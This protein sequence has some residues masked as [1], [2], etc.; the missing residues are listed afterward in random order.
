[1]TVESSRKVPKSF[2]GRRPMITRGGATQYRGG[3]RGG[4]QASNR[5]YQRQTQYTSLRGNRGGYNQRGRGSFRGRGGYRNQY[6][7]ENAKEPSLPILPSW[8]LVEEVEFD[9]L[10]V[11]ITPPTSET[12]LGLGTLERYVDSYD[13]ATPRLAK[14]VAAA[15]LGEV[16]SV[17]A[18][19]DT[20]LR[21][22]EEKKA[23]TV[24]AT[25]AVLS[26]LMTANKTV[27]PWDILVRRTPNAL[28]LDYRPTSKVDQIQC[29]EACLDVLPTESDSINTADALTIEA[30]RIARTVPQVLF[31]RASGSASAS[32]PAGGPE[33][34]VVAGSTQSTSIVLEGPAPN[35]GGNVAPSTTAYLYRRFELADDSQEMNIVARC[36]VDGYKP[37]T[38]PEDEPEYVVVKTLNEVDPKLIGS[39]DWRERL[40][41]QPA[42]VL[43]SE[44]KLGPSRISRIAAE[45]LLSGADLLKLVYVSRASPKDNTR[46]VILSTVTTKPAAFAL[47]VREMSR[48]LWGVLK[49]ILDTLWAQQPGKYV[50]LRD[51]NRQALQLYE[52]PSDAWEDSTGVMTVA[53]VTHPTDI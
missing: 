3:A 26:L 11:S 16:Y 28:Y 32:A 52:T 49:T 24:F 43:A 14:P 44:M 15:S 10:N 47:S 51:P 34:G 42:S 33:E 45:A 48:S 21:S 36:T 29:F 20:T 30:T 13:R 18:S 9:Q 8:N 39:F 6:R 12:L 25:E 2:L 19:G 50:L 7:E 22:L 41:N 38:P 37:A 31:P 35:A 40:E 23:G 46:H 17:T 4:A 5:G 1:M 27:A 53:P